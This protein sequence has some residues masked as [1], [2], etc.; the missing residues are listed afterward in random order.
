MEAFCSRAERGDPEESYAPLTNRDAD[1]ALKMG[2]HDTPG[3]QAPLVRLITDPPP[4]SVPGV[5]R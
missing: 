1:H 5:A 4:V 3:M 2:A